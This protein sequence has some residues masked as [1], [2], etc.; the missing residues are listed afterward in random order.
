MRKRGSAM[1]TSL[2][3]SSD[4]PCGLRTAICGTRPMLRKVVQDVF[5]KA[6]VHLQSFREEPSFEAWLTRILVNR[7]L[8]RIKARRRR[9][10]GSCPILTDCRGGKSSGTVSRVPA[11]SPEDRVVARERL[12]TLACALAACPNATLSD[13][14]EPLQRADVPGSGRAHGVEVVEGS[15]APVSGRAKAADA[16]GGGWNRTGRV[17]ARDERVGLTEM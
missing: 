17:D 6:Y 12:Q 5:L 7:C 4:G 2:R 10:R 14:V 9:T 3:R 13:H 1:E 11:V 15:R 16:S 8:D